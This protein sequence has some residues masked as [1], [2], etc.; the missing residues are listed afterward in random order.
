MIFIDTDVAIALR[1]VDPDT[2]GRIAELGEIPVI[3]VM[4]RIEL[5]NG[6]N[7]EPG[8]ANHRRRLLARLLETI[9]VEMFTAADIFAYGTIVYDL[10]YD[11]RT[12]IDRLIAAQA[13]SRDAQLITRNRRDFA[14]IEGL[15]LEVWPTL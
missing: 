11:R 8:L 5:E 3:S 4:T 6:A 10:G 15:R 12:T 9:V 13:I 2:Q 1:D 7:Q 14:R